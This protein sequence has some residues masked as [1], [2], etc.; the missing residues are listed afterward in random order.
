MM[1]TIT[2]NQMVLHNDDLPLAG[3][4]L[5]RMAGGMSA[6]CRPVVFG[7][8]RRLSTLEVSGDVYL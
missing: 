1:L 6:A 2:G 4:M 8:F 3:V 5:R 7:I